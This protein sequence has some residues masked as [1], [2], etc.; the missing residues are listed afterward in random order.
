[1]PDPRARD[2]RFP[3][4]PTHPDF[5][6]LSEAVQTH[7]AMA[8]QL[9]VNPFAITGVDEKSLSYFLENRIG[10]MMQ[11][12][13]TRILLAKAMVG[14]IWLDGFALGKRYAEQVAE[15]PECDRHGGTW[16][17][18]ETCPRCTRFVRTLEAGMTLASD[19][20]GDGTFLVVRDVNDPG[21]LLNEED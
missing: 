17:D 7:D 10:V 12:L 20:Q 5:I 13:G 11:R 19:P 21:P 18:D 2:P 15:R 1:M 8:E 6:R 14:A 16:G 3:D 9:D 4:R